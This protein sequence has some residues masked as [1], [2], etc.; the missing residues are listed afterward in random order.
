MKY[1]CGHEFSIITLDDNI[2]S[3]SAYFDWSKTVGYKGD[4]SLCWECY[5]KKDK[6]NQEP[7]EELIKKII[8]EL[9]LNKKNNISLYQIV[10]KT[11][12]LSETK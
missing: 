3:L 5:C 6:N 2:M 9:K 8:S 4:K 11:L 10:K 7:S 12:E 1:K